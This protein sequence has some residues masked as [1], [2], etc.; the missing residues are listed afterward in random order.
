MSWFYLILA[1][2]S[3][4]AGTLSMKLSN[5][6]TRLVPTLV[7]IVCYVFCFTA[8]TLAL[9]RLEVSIAYAIWAGVGTALVALAGILLFNEGVNW[10][11]IVSILLIVAGVI[12]LNLTGSAH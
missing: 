5:G 8:L 12:G 9:R 6:F 11:R 3:E 10:L 1:I 4:V 2:V 7:M